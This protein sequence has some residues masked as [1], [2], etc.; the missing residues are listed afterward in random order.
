LTTAYNAE[1]SLDEL[2]SDFAAR[3]LM[4][5]DGV[6]EGA[7]RAHLRAVMKAREAVHPARRSTV[8]P[9]GRYLG[10]SGD[11]AIR[12]GRSITTVTASTRSEPPTSSAT[13]PY[14]E[15]AAIVSA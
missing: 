14:R 5:A 6:Q 13:S 12:S 4:A 10:K 2:L 9:L 11:R 8:T 7:L 1:P 3:L 15:E